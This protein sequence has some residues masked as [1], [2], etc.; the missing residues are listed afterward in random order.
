MEKCPLCGFELKDKPSEVFETDGLIYACPNC[1]C[2][3]LDFVSR[4]NLPRVAEFG[5]DSLSVLSHVVR[6]MNRGDSCAKLDWDQIRR[7]LETT[8]LPLVTEQV[9]NILVWLGENTRFG[10]SIQLRPENH[11]AVMGAVGVEGAVAVAKA[12]VDLLY[13][14]GSLT[15]GGGFLGE[16]TFAGWQA[17]EQLLLGRSDSRKAFMAMQY[18]NAELDHVFAQCFKPAVGDTGFDLRRLDDAPPAGLIDDRLRVE[19]R[20]SRFL[21][22]DL[23]HQNRGAYWEAGFA[24]GLS[25]P[26]VYTCEIGVFKKE[27]THFDTSHHH[28]VVWDADDLGAAARELKDTIRATLPAEAILEDPD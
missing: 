16:L 1:G 14:R 20:T 21:I 7:I 26:V 13:A 18:G 27:G 5:P 25:K 10:D 11:A 19:I 3:E 4:A 22:A 17:I 23:T 12:L 8:H 15:S 2:Y 9:E 28:T 24:E 6:R